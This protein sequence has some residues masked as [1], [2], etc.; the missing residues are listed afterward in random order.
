RDIAVFDVLGKQV[1][2]RRLYGNVLD[3]SSL[4]SG[5]YIISITENAKTAVR[6]LVVK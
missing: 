4:T 3:V 6:K 5:I 2:G 1:L